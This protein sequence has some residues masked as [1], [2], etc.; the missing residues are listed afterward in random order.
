MD[1]RHFEYWK[2]CWKINLF[3]QESVV[4]VQKCV[5][6]QQAEGNGDRIWRSA[7]WREATTCSAGHSQLQPSDTTEHEPVVCARCEQTFVFDVVKG[8]HTCQVQDCRRILR[9]DI[10]IVRGKLNPRASTNFT[11]E[12]DPAKLLRY[13]ARYHSPR[14]WVLI[15][16][17]EHFSHSFNNVGRTNASYVPMTHHILRT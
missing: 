15:P 9:V 8:K 5:V 14:C 1:D 12:K 6:C 16:M 7:F 11:L 13:V 3:F 4:R 17:L 2:V 10:D